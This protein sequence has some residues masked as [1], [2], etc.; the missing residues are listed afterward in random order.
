[1]YGTDNGPNMFTWPDGA[2]TPFRN[3]K[4]TNWEGAFR[5]PCLVRWPGK[6]KPGTVFEPDGRA[7]RL[8]ADILRDGRREVHPK[9]ERVAGLGL[10]FDVID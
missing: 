6:I 10:P 7:S 8:A 9:E 4:N 1:M 5:V 2:M 3:E